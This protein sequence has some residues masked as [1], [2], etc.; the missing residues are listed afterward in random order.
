MEQGTPFNVQITAANSP[1]SFSLEAGL[2]P[3]MTLNTSTGLYSG[4]PTVRIARFTP[5]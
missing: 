4:T 3:G 5:R 1:V 2:V